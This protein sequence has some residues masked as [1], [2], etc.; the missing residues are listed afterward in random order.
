M[1][2]TKAQQHQV[3][4]M[5]QFENGCFEASGFACLFMASVSLLFSPTAPL[6]AWFI[7]TARLQT[8]TWH[9]YCLLSWSLCV[10]LSLPFIT[11]FTAPCLCLSVCFSPSLIGTVSV[12]AH[13]LLSLSAFVLHTGSAHCLA[14]SPSCIGCLRLCCLFSPSLLYINTRNKTTK[15]ENWIR[16]QQDSVRWFSARRLE[17]VRKEVKEA[18]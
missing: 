17:G 15:R 1:N 4:M 11:L 9:L 7:H 18:W 16:Y 5:R 8:L 2:Y 13:I 12:G 3:F 10:V 14:A 6:P